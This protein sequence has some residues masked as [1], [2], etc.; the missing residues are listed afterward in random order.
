MQCQKAEHL[1]SPAH[2]WLSTAQVIDAAGSRASAAVPERSH[3]EHVTGAVLGPLGGLWPSARQVPRRGAGSRA[4]PAAVRDVTRA[5][6]LRSRS[7]PGPM[8]TQPRRP[9]GL[10]SGAGRTTPTVPVVRTVRNKD[11][12]WRLLVYR[13]PVERPWPRT[14][15]DLDAAAHRAHDHSWP[16]GVQRGRPQLAERRSAL[17]GSAPRPSPERRWPRTS[18]KAQHVSLAEHGRVLDAAQLA[19]RPTAV[20][21]AQMEGRARGP[22]TAPTRSS[23]SSCL[24]AAR[25]AASVMPSRP[26]R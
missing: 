8:R 20:H 26:W 14:A 9:G 5:A 11:A 12:L 10:T 17:P 7:A 21:R 6:G 16:S 13:P 4:Q 22:G 23:P 25:R 15:R 3:L 24:Y 1:S 18:C 19:N 2:S